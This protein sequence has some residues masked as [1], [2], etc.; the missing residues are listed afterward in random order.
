[1]FIQKQIEIKKNINKNTKS[2]VKLRLIDLKRDEFI[3]EKYLSVSKVY[4]LLYPSLTNH[5]V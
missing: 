2:E 5:T 4:L 1:M 3:I